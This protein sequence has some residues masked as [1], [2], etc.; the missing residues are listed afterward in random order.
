MKIMKAKAAVSAYGTLPG[1]LVRVLAQSAL[2]LQPGD[3]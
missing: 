2:A 3:R 1:G